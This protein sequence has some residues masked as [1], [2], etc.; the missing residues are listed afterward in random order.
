MPPGRTRGPRRR[1]QTR[2][3][4]FLAGL[5][6]G[7]ALV[8]VCV[9]AYLLLGRPPVAVTD[10]PALWDALLT[11][12][13]LRQRVRAEAKAP[14]FS[15]DEQVF[16]TGARLYRVHCAQCHGVP[17]QVSALGLQMAPR[18]QQFFSTRNRHAAAGPAGEIFWKT[19]FGIRHSGMPA[20]NHL[21]G[22]TELWQVSLL[23]HAANTSLPDP[24]SA[25]LLQGTAPAQ[26]TL[27]VP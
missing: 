13:L 12:L 10:R 9:L 14:P 4:P 11:T 5:G 26:P 20:Y 24:V 16:E 19:A 8:F 7:V 6:T 17:G 18:A 15:A 27:V 21:L 2:T 25:I 1:K 3:V 22:N 23:L